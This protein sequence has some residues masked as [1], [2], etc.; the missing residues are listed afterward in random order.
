MNLAGKTAIVTGGGSGIG[1]AIVR[2]FAAQG[3]AVIIADWNEQ[4]ASRLAEE[5]TSSGHQVVEVKVDVSRDSDV[6]ELIQET[7]HR[8]GQLDVLVNNAAV[9]LPK[10]LEEVE[11]EEWDRLFN[12]NLKSVFLMVKH[13]IAELRKTRGA[14]VNMA[15]LNGLIGQKMNPVYAATKGGVV[16]MTKALALDYAPDGVRVNCICPAGV[17]T[18]LLQHWIQEQDDPMATIKILNDMHPI[19]RPATS[20]E[21]AQ[22]ALFLAST[23]SGFITGV[24][25]PVDGGAS[26]GY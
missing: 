7:L 10:F 8:F 2:L 23:Q 24:A 13:A 14:I 6:R 18:P 19:G 9:I 17:S 12:I 11:E 3:A 16:A 1:E 21:V 20:E 26:L 5:L 25:L 22:A 4:G 15:S